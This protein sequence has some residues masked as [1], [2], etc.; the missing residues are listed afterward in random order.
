[1]HC[2]SSRRRLALAAVGLIPVAVLLAAC[3][4]STSP[5]AQ[6]TA[7]T[8]GVNEGNAAELYAATT[9][10]DTSYDSY[11]AGEDGDYIEAEVNS[12]TDF[13][14]Y[15]EIVEFPLPPLSGSGVVDSAR[16]SAY[17]CSNYNGN[18]QHAGTGPH[19]TGRVTRPRHSLATGHTVRTFS[20]TDT[21][22]VLLDHMDWGGSFTGSATFWGEALAVNIGTLMSESE[23]SYGWKTVS[24]SASVAADYA[25]HRTN[26]QFR[27]R[28]N[29]AG[30]QSLDSFVGFYGQ[31]C[32]DDLGVGGPMT[33]VVWSH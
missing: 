13:L 8:I 7:D 21:A 16:F 3:G 18:Y 23:E 2:L 30:W 1:M 4:S 33:L 26:S 14:E 10:G 32:N 6:S 27:I 28:F 24:V 11:G 29:D 22:S 25:A 20:V 9:G 31:D 15:R 5:R 12:A 19:T 17:V